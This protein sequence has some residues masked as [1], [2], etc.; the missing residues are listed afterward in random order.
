MLIYGEKIVL[1]AVEKADNTMLLSLINDPDTEMMLGGSSWPVSESDQLKWF[2]HQEHSRDVLR[3]IVALQNDGRALG[4][5]ILSDIDQ[6]NATGHIHIKMLK[7]GGR[8]RGYG[9]D[10]VKT[11]VRYAFEELRLNCIYANILAYNDASIKLFER[12][13]FKKDGVLRQRVYKKGKF[14][15]MLAYSI[16]ITE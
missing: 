12:C 14:V 6:K 4:T 5:I 2:E 8:G 11:M 15:D 9:T 7:D 3:C 10:A 1:R 13:G 16:L